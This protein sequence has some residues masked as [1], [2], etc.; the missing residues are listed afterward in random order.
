MQMDYDLVTALQF[1]REQMTAY[2]IG[3]KITTHPCLLRQ[4][5][6]QCFFLTITIVIIQQL[7][8]IWGFHQLTIMFI[9]LDRMESCKILVLHHIGCLK[10]AVK[11]PFH[12]RLNVC[13]TGLRK[14]IRYC[15]LQQ[16]LLRW[17][18]SPTPTIATILKQIPY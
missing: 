11:R 2:L 15:S 7:M 14:A 10:Q 13:S 1:I 6:H 4:V 12:P 8:P 9:T 18:H 3:Q 16:V 5:L 17:L